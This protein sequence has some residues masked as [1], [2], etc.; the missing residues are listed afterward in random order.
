MCWRLAF[1]MLC[2]A[3]SVAFAQRTPLDED[4]TLAAGFYA[5]GQ[6]QQAEQ[7]FNK[8]IR[9][10]PETEQATAAEFFLPESLMQQGEYERAYS[11]F[12]SFLKRHPKNT[13]APRATFR[14]GESALRSGKYDVS[15]RLLEEF[16]KSN[17]EHELNEFAL[18]YLGELRT[19]REEP[20][21]A[22]M[23]FETSLRLYPNGALVNQNRLGLAKALQKQ[24]KVPGNLAE[25]R[26]FY[27]FLV[28]ELDPEIATE[29]RIQIGVIELDLFNFSAAEANLIQAIQQTDSVELRAKGH[30][31]LARME[32]EQDSYKEAL[33]QLE[34]LAELRLEAPLQTSIWYDGAVAAAKAGRL[35]K[36][37][38]WLKQIREVH[39]SSRRVLAAV[40]LEI[41][42]LRQLEKFDQALR[43]AEKY[44]IETK[45]KDVQQLATLTEIR[46][47]YEAGNYQ[48]V[49][50]RVDQS[51]ESKISL[52]SRHRASYFKALA[53]IGLQ[54]WS[55]AQ[56]TLRNLSKEVDSGELAS[57][58]H[59]AV[60]TCHFSQKEYALAIQHYERYLQSPTSED[61]RWRANAELACCLVKTRQFVRADQ[62]LQNWVDQS[63]EAD[64]NI[65]AV[66]ELLADQAMQAKQKDI[67]R[68]WFRYLGKHSQDP[69]RKNRAESRVAISAIDLDSPN[70]LTFSAFEQLLDSSSTKNSKQNSSTCKTAIAAAHKLES[71]DRKQS[72]KL[73]AL[74]ADRCHDPAVANLARHRLA[75]LLKESGKSEHLKRAFELLNQYVSESSPTAKPLL[76]ESLYQLAWLATDLG[77]RSEGQAYFRRLSLECEDSKYWPDA[78]YRWMQHELSAGNDS[79]AQEL[80]DKLTKRSLD[81]AQ[82]PKTI[83][84]RTQF[85]QGQL[86]VRQQNWTQLA[87]AMNSLPRPQLSPRLGA[88]ADYWAAEADYQL[89]NAKAALQ[90]LKSLRTNT[91]L[92]DQRRP[93][94][95]L[96]TAQLSAKQSDWNTV[97]DCCREGQKFSRFAGRSEFVFL[98]AR[99]WERKGRL[100]DAR[101]A[102]EKV[103]AS[104]DSAG[105]ELAAQAQWRIGELFFHQERYADAIAA[106]YKV[107]SLY[108]FER[109][110]S[111]ALIQAGKCQ[112]LLGQ[113]QQAKK[114]YQ[115]LIRQFQTNQY[116]SEAKERL[117]AIESRL[118]TAKS[119]RTPATK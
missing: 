6:W 94:V 79:V 8:L 69:A 103:I 15:L 106:Y 97:A 52:D 48:S 109:W 4:Y 64:R 70:E 61:D 96:R 40:H 75:T 28:R 2:L 119:T 87:A 14:M 53:L 27:D 29:A 85:A 92:S 73:Y 12:Q 33:V 24:P 98:E 36:A 22:Q 39:P 76:D 38:A 116:A 84:I 102:F 108:E 46:Q 43:L 78:T 72:W 111:A 10:Y 57:L 5:R 67:G 58:V 31:W 83:A 7:A 25:A 26:R 1:A 44:Q 113:P 30:Y 107:D 77:E 82:F 54:D 104:P 100:T 45:I 16:V 62:V 90:Q 50:D 93:W 55:N 101:L 71:R 9:Q 21:L 11:A 37:I 118:R 114:L 81:Q 88:Q 65:E 34:P 115:Q 110:R 117:S 99:C 32:L 95:L 42:L 63:I 89:G 112:E 49:I 18:T 59:L 80:L 105:T 66:M 17:P 68:K 51:S 41:D 23:A 35:T 60:A 3:S 19:L 56:S 13:Y 47:D 20:Q 91:H 74:V 86:A